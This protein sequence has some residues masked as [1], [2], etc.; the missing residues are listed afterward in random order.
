MCTLPVK[1]SEKEMQRPTVRRRR[2]GDIPNTGII[3]DAVAFGTWYIRK[4][5]PLGY[6]LIWPT[7]P[8]KLI[9]GNRSNG[10]LILDTLRPGAR[11]V[12]FLY[13]RNR[14]L[15]EQER[16]TWD[17]V[18]KQPECTFYDLTTSA[19][20]EPVEPVE[21]LHQIRLRLVRE[22]GVGGGGVALR[23]DELTVRPFMPMVLKVGFNS[24]DAENERT[25]GAHINRW[26][27]GGRRSPNFVMSMFDFVCPGLPPDEGTWRRRLL[28]DQ[29]TWEHLSIRKFVNDKFQFF[30]DLVK[31]GHLD[32]IEFAY[33]GIEFGSEG[34]AH[35]FLWA[36]EGPGAGIDLT[37]SIAF[38]LLF[39]L[40]VLHEADTLHG[41][42]HDQNVVFSRIDPHP[43]TGDF[44]LYFIEW[45]E[46]SGE[47]TLQRSTYYDPHLIALSND[48]KNPLGKELDLNYQVK[49]IDY[50]SSLRAPADE[51]IIIGHKTGVIEG[52]P[53][54][55]IFIDREPLEILSK[56]DRWLEGDIIVP[57]TTE[58][59]LW[60]VGIIIAKAALNGEHPFML[61]RG[62][63]GGLEGRMPWL[64]DVP[65]HILK[66]LW[67]VIVTPGGRLAGLKAQRIYTY[68]HRQVHTIGNSFAFMW[69]AV[70]ALGLPTNREWPGIEKS[71]FWKIIH[72]NS[73]RLKYG[74]EGGGWMRAHVFPDLTTDLGKELARRKVLLWGKMDRIAGGMDMLLNDLLAWAPQKRTS[75]LE[76]LTKHPYFG[77]VRQGGNALIDQ[78]LRT[79]DTI[80]DPKEKKEFIDSHIWAF[81]EGWWGR[82]KLRI[83]R[84]KKK[85]KKKRRKKKKKGKKE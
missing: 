54:E 62:H 21:P 35:N 53:P 79:S 63:K 52:N 82:A 22:L 69:N 30:N 37:R 39:G 31:E 2:P 83:V 34:D 15:S 11:Y 64:M 55:L 74:Q 38:Q 19:K 73:S 9:P 18:L 36:E 33:L 25:I 51:I 48:Q 24:I 70:E 14:G 61:E 20:G 3:T 65:D 46:E 8:M 44:P 13:D 72:D 49:F 66:Q 43:R 41:D 59:E 45:F 75:A 76:L 71:S 68:M 1:N 42:I 16:D 58:S 12:E 17:V 28:P 23:V 26:I 40:A 60:S 50:G 27:L 7:D 4:R 84:D 29:K 6:K 81:S 56:T 85:K 10:R 32:K 5:K 67:D 47:E 78:V 77:L 57:Y 80:M